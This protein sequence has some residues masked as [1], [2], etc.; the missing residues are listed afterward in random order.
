MGLV[1][2]VFLG[3]KKSD[4]HK[5]FSGSYAGWLREA[6]RPLTTLSSFI[7]TC[8]LPK[9]GDVSDEQGEGFHRD[10]SVTEVRREVHPNMMGDC[11]WL[12]QRKRNVSDRR[13]STPATTSQQSYHSM[14][15]PS[16]SLKK[17]V[18]NRKVRVLTIIQ[19]HQCNQHVLI[20]QHTSITF[21]KLKNFLA[22]CCHHNLC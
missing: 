18:Q 15:Q 11:W 9:V 14:S 5:H 2:D 16:I 6:R 8:L 3:K 10:I 7:Y 20:I 12:L 22:L 4:D 17:K 19:F 13:R 21:L 1:L